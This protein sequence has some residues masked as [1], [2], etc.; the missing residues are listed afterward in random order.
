MSGACDCSEYRHGTDHPTYDENNGRC[1]FYP[2]QYY[3][4]RSF[5]RIEN[6]SINENLIEVTYSGKHLTKGCDFE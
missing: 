4:T 5:E 6:I 1:D 3:I 2:N